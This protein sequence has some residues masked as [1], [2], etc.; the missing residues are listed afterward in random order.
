M[1]SKTDNSTIPI[2]K[3]IQFSDIFEIEEIQHL[4][5]L[6]SNA[7]GVA[8]IITH[9]DGTPITKPSNFCRLCNEIIRNT[10]KGKL[11][12]YYSDSILGRHSLSGPTIRTCLSGDLWDAGVSITVGGQHIANWMIGQVKN[13]KSNIQHM[14]KYAEE[15]GVDKGLYSEALKEIPEMTY[16][17]FSSVANMLFQFVNHMSEKTY[18]SFLLKKQNQE[19]NEVTSQLRESEEKYRMLVENSHDLIF[20]I[21]VKGYFT[22]ISPLGASFL[23]YETEEV[24]GQSFIKFVHPDDFSLFL[25]S[26]RNLRKNSNHNQAFEYR[27]LHKNGNSHWHNAHVLL[28]LDENG[29]IKSYYGLAMDN[30]AQR[31]AE[32]EVLLKNK[33]LEKAN[34]VKDKFFSIVAHDLRSPFGSLLGLSRMLSEDLSEF[35]M[36]QI[37]HISENIY[38]T[39]DNLYRLLE[40]MLQWS[41]IQ[42]DLVTFN[43]EPVVLAHVANESFN[44]Y[45]DVIKNKGIKADI[46]IPSNLLVYTD[47]NILQTVFRNLISNAAKFTPRGGRIDIT[48]SKKDSN[49]VEVIVKDTGIGMTPELLGNIFRPDISTGRRGT[50]NEPSTGLGLLLCKEFIEKQGGQIYVESENEKGSIFHFTVPCL[51][52]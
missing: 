35:T 20:S 22:Y 1:S 31:T 50:D 42:Q 26:L 39:A 32:H 33:E 49:F 44:L 3:N 12:C 16:E 40:N 4:Q 36:D 15:I 28:I 45:S 30:T 13:E 23:G 27:V 29:A 47:I 8:S 37:Q 38:E 2:L 21:D 11:N 5:D 43:L 48:A 52:S 7:T 10:E 25:K 46:D 18:S 19:L 17:R 6:F 24:I 51:A 34:R 9:I 41:K 14:L